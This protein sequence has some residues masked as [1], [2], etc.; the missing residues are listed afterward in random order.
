QSPMMARCL[1]NEKL[2]RPVF[3]GSMVAEGIVALIWAAAAITFTG[4]YAE[5]GDYLSANAAADLVNDISMGWL[6]TV[7]GLL[8]LLGVVAAPIT[9]GDTALRSARLIVSDMF[10]VDQ[11][12]LAKRLLVS[13]P[14]FAAAAALMMIDYSILWR[15]FA[16]CNQ[17]LSVFT[18]W[19]ATVYLARHNRAYV[20]TLVPAIFMTVVVITYILFAPQPEGFG[21]GI[22]YATGIGVL[23]AAIFTAL[24]ARYLILLRRGAIVHNV[25]Y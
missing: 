6:G 15:Y 25:A 13:V 9:T 16:W 11:T 24:F 17:T 19:A 22:A 21:L 18:L 10:H 7:G 1:K 14:I 20:I 3:Y 8:A 4:G 23:V 12:K 2:A 5:L